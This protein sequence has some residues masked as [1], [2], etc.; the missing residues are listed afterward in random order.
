[1]PFLEPVSKVAATFRG[2]ILRD[3]RISFL[4]VSLKTGA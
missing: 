1:M 4:G 2:E 3:F